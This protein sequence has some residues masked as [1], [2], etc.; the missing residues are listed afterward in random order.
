MALR[1]ID[2]DVNVI[3][4]RRGPYDG[5]TAVYLA[6]EIGHDAVIDLLWERLANLDQPKKDGTTALW[7][8]A[9]NGRDRAVAALVR[10]ASS[11]RWSSVHGTHEGKA[12]GHT[13]AVWNT[14]RW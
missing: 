10:R 9:R 5:L 13:A 6:A 7:I 8:A 3:L 4:D 1:A 2:S 12:C 11:P 14:A